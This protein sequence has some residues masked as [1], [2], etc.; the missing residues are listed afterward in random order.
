MGISWFAI[1]GLA[2]GCAILMWGCAGSYVPAAD[3]RVGVLVCG[4]NVAL[5]QLPV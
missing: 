1:R 3:E 4:A 5:D 2:L